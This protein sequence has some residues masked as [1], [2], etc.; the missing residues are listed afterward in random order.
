MEIVSG[1][2]RLHLTLE[3]LISHARA[4][5][6]EPTADILGILLPHLIA[7]LTIRA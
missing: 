4:T 3:Q 6:Q 1:A 5:S 7:E 2:E